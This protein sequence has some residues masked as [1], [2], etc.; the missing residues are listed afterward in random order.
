MPLLSSVLCPLSS[1]ASTYRHVVVKRNLV[2]I[3]KGDVTLGRAIVDPLPR[4][5]A[6]DD[7]LQM[8][9]ANQ[10]VRAEMRKGQRHE[11]QG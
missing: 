3:W 8:P 10:W 1:V 2:A 9:A 4:Q 6:A 5:I 11:R 7:S